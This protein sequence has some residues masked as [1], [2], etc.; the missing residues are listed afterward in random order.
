MALMGVVLHIA[1]IQSNPITESRSARAQ[2][3][4]ESGRE[5]PR[6]QS[7]NGAFFFGFL[8]GPTG[9]GVSAFLRSFVSSRCQNMTFIY[10]FFA[11]F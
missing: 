5:R 3:A 4:C 8:F 11:I 7:Q 6:H 9:L 1:N 2:H 10:L